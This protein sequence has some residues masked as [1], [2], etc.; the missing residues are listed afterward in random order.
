M[1]L[2][3]SSGD[4]TKLASVRTA[5]PV[6]NRKG[7]CLVIATDPQELCIRYT[8]RV[9]AGES[10]VEEDDRKEEYTQIV[11]PGTDRRYISF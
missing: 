2:D 7:F 10:A 6:T 4:I 11:Y 9:C 1:T 8:L 3:S 5:G